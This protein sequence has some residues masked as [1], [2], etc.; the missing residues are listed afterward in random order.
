MATGRHRLDVTEGFHALHLGF[1]VPYR[2]LTQNSSLEHVHIITQLQVG[3]VSCLPVTPGLGIVLRR[4]HSRLK[5][6]RCPVK[7]TVV[8]YAAHLSCISEDTIMK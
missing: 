3:L 4:W 7:T 8:H 6:W 5:T 1:Q 2:R